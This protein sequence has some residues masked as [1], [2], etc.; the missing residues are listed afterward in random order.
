MCN[1]IDVIYATSSDN[2]LPPKSSS[3]RS[4]R[5]WN[6]KAVSTRVSS[7]PELFKT[8]KSTG[9]NA[10][11]YE[12]IVIVT[13]LKSQCI[14]RRWGLSQLESSKPRVTIMHMP[15]R[16]SVSWS[17]I[18]PSR[19]MMQLLITWCLLGTRAFCKHSTVTGPPLGIIETESL[20]CRLPSHFQC[21]CL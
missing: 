8:I 17:R 1:E 11:S 4:S 5:R 14:N 7:W 13:A 2:N 21:A 16:L 10:C 18:A 9:P 19:S 3:R 6:G 12:K 20:S 15:W